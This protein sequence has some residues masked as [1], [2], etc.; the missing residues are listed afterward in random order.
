MAG[1]PTAHEHMVSRNEDKLDRFSLHSA[2]EE[3][4]VLLQPKKQRNITNMVFGNEPPLDPKML[5]PVVYTKK[6]FSE[7]P[8]DK[9]S[10]SIINKDGNYHSMV[11]T[12]TPA[13][14]RAGLRSGVFPPKSIKNPIARAIAQVGE[15][16][17]RTFELSY[18]EN[19]KIDKLAERLVIV[20][21][22]QDMYTTL[23]A[24]QG[25]INKYEEKLN[26]NP[27]LNAIANIDKIS[28]L[29]T[30][31]LEKMSEIKKGF[32]AD[33]LTAAPYATFLDGIIK[34]EQHVK[35]YKTLLDKM[36]K[37]PMLTPEKV[38]EIVAPFGTPTL[39]NPDGNQVTD[40]SL[41]HFISTQMNRMSTHARK[42]NNDLTGNYQ[43]TSGLDACLIEAKFQVEDYSSESTDLHNNVAKQH[44][45]DFIDNVGENGL[46]AMNMGPY[47]S[48]PDEIELAKQLALM[49]NVQAEKPLTKDTDEVKS[50]IGI[51]F[52]GNPLKALARWTINGV[53]QTAGIIGDIGYNL[54]GG[55]RLWNKNGRAPS[56][57]ITDGKEKAFEAIHHNTGVDMDPEETLYKHSELTKSLFDK[58]API[59]KMPHTGMA[60]KAFNIVGGFLKN[61]VVGPVVDG[62]KYAAREIARG[63]RVVYDDIKHGTDKVSDKEITVLLSQRLSESAANRRSNEVEVEAVT[64]AYNQQIRRENSAATLYN[65]NLDKQ[66]AANPQ[67]FADNP[68]RPDLQKKE[69]KEIIDHTEFEH[70]MLLKKGICGEAKMP[71]S[72][73]FDKG[74]DAFSW[75]LG[76][77]YGDIAGVFAKDIYRPHPIAGLAFTAA[78]STAA[79]MMFPFLAQYAVFKSMLV[80]SDAVG[81]TIAGGTSGMSA[82]VSTALVE[83]KIAFL[84]VD[85]F[86]GRDSIL[87]KGLK[88]V[89][90]NPLP[91]AAIG[92]IAV[93]VGQWVA[94]QSIPM[95]SEEAANVA[96]EATFPYFELALVGAKV[97]AIAVEGTLN[98]ESESNEPLA[99]E[100]DKILQEQRGEIIKSFTDGLKVKRT[101][102]ESFSAE[103]KQEL[104]A[105][106]QAAIDKEITKRVETAIEI[107]TSSANPKKDAPNYAAFL[108]GKIAEFK[109]NLPADKMEAITKPVTQLETCKYKIELYDAKNSAKLTDADEKIMQKNVQGWCQNIKSKTL[110]P[111]AELEGKIAQFSEKIQEEVA[112]DRKKRGLPELPQTEKAKEKWELQRKA[113][114]LIDR[115]TIREN[116]E[117]TDPKTLS[118]EDKAKIER[119]VIQHYPN[120]PDYVSA[121]M[122]HLREDKPSGG[123]LIESVKMAV[124]YPFKALRAGAYL[125]AT[126]Y[127]KLRNDQEK[128]DMSY[129]QV[130]KFGQQAV[131]DTGLVIKGV[132]SALR[133]TWSLVA[134]PFM[135]P[136]VLIA[137]TLSGGKYSEADAILDSALFAPGRVSQLI[138][139]VTGEMRKFEGGMNLGLATS[140]MDI[141][142]HQQFLETV[143]KDK[144]ISITKD[145]DAD[146]NQNTETLTLESIQKHFG[147]DAKLLKIIA[148]ATTFEGAMEAIQ[149]TIVQNKLRESQ[150]FFSRVTTV[151]PYLDGKMQQALLNIRSDFS[152]P[153]LQQQSRMID[154]LINNMDKDPSVEFKKAYSDVA[155]FKISEAYSSNAELQV[156]AKNITAAQNALKKLDTS[157]IPNAPRETT[158]ISLLKSTPNLS[159]TQARFDAQ[160]IESIKDNL[161]LQ[162]SG[163]LSSVRKSELN[164]D[165]NIAN[166]L[167]EG[168]D[169]IIK[170]AQNARSILKAYAGTTGQL[171]QSVQSTIQD[172]EALALRVLNNALSKFPKLASITHNK[173]TFAS[174]SKALQEQFSYSKANRVSLPG[175]TPARLTHS[176]MLDSLSALY[177]AHTSINN[178]RQLSLKERGKF[179]AEIDT[180]ID[181]NKRDPA[182]E[183]K[184]AY[185]PAL[186][187]LEALKATPPIEINKYIL[188]PAYEALLAAQIALANFQPQALKGVSR[189]QAV[190]NIL[191]QH[192]CLSLKQSALQLSVLETYV[193]KAQQIKQDP[194]KPL[195]AGGLAV[196]DQNIKCAMGMIEATKNILEAAKQANS[197]LAIYDKISNKLARIQ[198]KPESLTKPGVEKQESPFMEL[199]EQKV[200]ALAS[201]PVDD[202]NL[203]QKHRSNLS[204]DIDPD[205]D[206]EIKII[207]TH[208]AA[209][210]EQVQLQ[211][212]EEE[213]LAQPT[214]SDDAHQYFI[215][216]DQGVI[217]LQTLETLQGR[218]QEENHEE[219]DNMYM[220]DPSLNAAASNDR[221]GSDFYRAST[222]THDSPQ[223]QPMSLRLSSSQTLPAMTNG[224]QQTTSLGQID[225]ETAKKLLQ[226]YVEECIKQQSYNAIARRNLQALGVTFL[227]RGE[228]PSARITSTPIAPGWQDIC[229]TSISRDTS[230][231]TLMKIPTGWEPLKIDSLEIDDDNNSLARFSTHA[232]FHHSDTDATFQVNQNLNGS[233]SMDITPS[234]EDDIDHSFGLAETRD[235]LKNYVE[236]N[237]TGKIDISGGPEKLAKN[238]MLLC[239]ANGI[240]FENNTAFEKPALVKVA[241][242]QQNFESILPT[243]Q[244]MISP[245]LESKLPKDVFNAA[246]Q[247]YN[248]ENLGTD[249]MRD[250]G[251]TANKSAAATIL[252]PLEDRHIDSNTSVGPKR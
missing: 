116:I 142:E 56:E 71:H 5:T 14:I 146:I 20:D 82:V 133:S 80:V 136:A 135:T 192:P 87:S 155:S 141:R 183:F 243:S 92:T 223:A 120:D 137:G 115:R 77:F 29:L 95:I 107:D 139:K 35:G 134:A 49:N 111:S 157:Y 24:F 245:D 28:D 233:Y 228:R 131:A 205:G 160:R 106:I 110:K 172:P 129:A 189:E 197:R 126:G 98:L 158:I 238:M 217:T 91:A 175:A 113:Q 153:A 242:V 138:D 250:L 3:K 38:R 21:T 239:M 216:S 222:V 218:N 128:A 118:S 33:K 44:N 22:I 163:N 132:A 69:I 252:P 162:L 32:P 121:V 88:L 152:G 75:I 191:D 83:G 41:Q 43:D 101:P 147:N 78:A 58:K 12:T 90:E 105:R 200:Q 1:L 18:E 235:A 65:E 85:A 114:E 209:D 72:L 215:P 190:L 193:I 125:A 53:A 39:D 4:I 37:D 176:D 246:I 23:E 31:Q 97:I 181:A 225:T 79:P 8:G 166:N 167:L 52:S 60:Q 66:R 169:K 170:A 109:L 63:V 185:Q 48:P 76:D 219:S 208:P 36:A 11:W 46:V 199:S 61:W 168:Y 161:K 50:G 96:A 201:N 180:L 211:A 130:K 150:G 182:V 240:D 206:E 156:F 112:L 173:N 184:S 165:L 224:K 19:V 143:N 119:Y 123:P 204:V 212:E 154:R 103:Q 174:A 64:A 99:N 117:R 26:P 13:K 210:N 68:N 84:A 248:G 234:T 232:T 104:N 251:K 94:T 54:L 221:N 86:N 196:I 237:G 249:T 151:A 102:E 89:L 177:E 194:I 62:V 164:K 100:I 202:P 241:E 124:S 144:P 231:Q 227:P 67:L 9:S 10:I 74:H 16:K 188:K 226:P 47:I 230:N 42:A 229:G 244:V 187:S 27:Q 179:Q 203:E 127:H 59:T 186:S 6:L 73:E 149:A 40:P 17:R 145:A 70:D 171:T 178:L 51:K 55:G 214:I 236:I 159:L 220:I 198:D 122:H 7:H 140:M 148:N 93:A 2:P 108:M 25:C 247:L 81:K 213:K 57:V 34:L 15:F 207:A 195:T 30:K 45:M